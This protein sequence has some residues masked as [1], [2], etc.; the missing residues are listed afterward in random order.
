[1]LKKNDLVH[2]FRRYERFKIYSSTSLT[3][4][5][6]PSKTKKKLVKKIFWWKKILVEKKNPPLLPKEGSDVCNPT[7]N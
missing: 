7:L 1:M 4:A 5:L 3:T 6:T 2:Y